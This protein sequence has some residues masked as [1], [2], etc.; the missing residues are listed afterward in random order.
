M[1][2]NFTAED[3]KALQKA[4]KELLTDENATFDSNKRNHEFFESMA[5]KYNLPKQLLFDE[6]DFR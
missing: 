5:K 4:K 6:I 1:L 2:A 3:Y